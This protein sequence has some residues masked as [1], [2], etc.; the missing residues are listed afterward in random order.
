MSSM[1]L[2]AEGIS[3]NH[4]RTVK[5]RHLSLIAILL[6]FS[7]QAV[8]IVRWRNGI[9]GLEMHYCFPWAMGSGMLLSAQFIALS[10]W[11]PQEQMASATAVYYLSQQI[12]LIIGTS[13][14]TA[15]LQRLFGY[16]LEMNLVDIVA[17]EKT[18]VG[19]PS[20]SSDSLFD[21]HSEIPR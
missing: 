10:I 6:S 20:P 12:G 2:S 9:Q 18:K 21:T 15:A 13:V 19:L 16:R 3:S 8:M 4:H 14:S 17:P 1:I 7:A 5:Y 11:S